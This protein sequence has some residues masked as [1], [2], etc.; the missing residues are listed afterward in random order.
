METW[1]APKST[2]TFSSQREAERHVQSSPRSKP[3]APCTCVAGVVFI[4]KYGRIRKCTTCRLLKDNAEARQV[5]GRLFEVLR[6][7]LKAR[8][9]TTEDAILRLE[10]SPELLAEESA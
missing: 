2:P 1:K 8:G 10:Q 3:P 5:A 4:E 7:E 9:G 6:G